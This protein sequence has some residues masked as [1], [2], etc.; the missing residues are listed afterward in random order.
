MFWIV[1]KESRFFFF[2]LVRENFNLWC[3]LLITHW[4]SLFFIFFSNLQIWLLFGFF[5]NLIIDI[6][7]SFLTS[8]NSDEAVSTMGLKALILNAFYGLLSRFGFL[9]LSLYSFVF[10]FFLR[11][12][13]QFLFNNW[14]FNFCFLRVSA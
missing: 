5:F 2:F 9:F 1:R 3:L 12:S 11:W 6:P 4:F 7:F 14:F 10:H 8:F 13:D